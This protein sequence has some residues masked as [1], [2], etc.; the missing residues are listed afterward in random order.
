ME[1]TDPSD[2]YPRAVGD[3]WALE[4]ALKSSTLDAIAGWVAEQTF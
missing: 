4:E 1:P 3:A 2:A